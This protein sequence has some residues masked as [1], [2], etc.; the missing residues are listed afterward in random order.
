M[1]LTNVQSSLAPNDQTG[2]RF[3]Q[4]P[5]EVRLIILRQLLRSDKPIYSLGSTDDIEYFNSI[6]RSTQLLRTCQLLHNEGLAILYYENTL[7]VDFMAYDPD[8]EEETVHYCGILQMFLPVPE[9]LKGSEEELLSLIKY[10]TPKR[11][12]DC[13]DSG[14]MMQHCDDL[15]KQWG[16]LRKFNR[17]QIR[18]QYATQQVVFSASRMLQDLLQNKDVKFTLNVVD[19]DDEY[20]VPETEFDKT[21]S[22]MLRSCRI[23]RCTSMEFE[24]QNFNISPQPEPK[25]ADDIEDLTAVITGSSLMDDTYSEWV[26]TRKRLI[27]F[28]DA[29]DLGEFEEDYDEDFRALQQAAMDY[30]STT[31][32]NRV[33]VFLTKLKKDIREDAENKLSTCHDD[34]GRYDIYEDRDERIAYIEQ[35]FDNTIPR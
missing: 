7:C 21:A 1:T 2:S 29:E 32:K 33:A 15:V 13:D 28:F 8:S 25:L 26:S 6:Q 34:E 3:L 18:V 9:K 35:Q 27:H 11:A 17:F 12:A 23:L 14:L 5:A 19:A 30:E 16:T 24:T 10:A 31:Y 4:L 20:R 22:Q